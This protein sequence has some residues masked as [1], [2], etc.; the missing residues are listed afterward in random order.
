M[1]IVKPLRLKVQRTPTE[2]KIAPNLGVAKVLVDTGIFHLSGTYDYAVPIGLDTKAQPGTLVEVPF[3]S[4]VCSGYIVSRHSEATVTG[5][6]KFISKVLSPIPIFTQ[7]LHALLEDV[8]KLFAC[9]VWDLIRSAIPPRVAKVE[10]NFSGRKPPV[11]LEARESRSPR[12]VLKV[13]ST[14]LL[15]L[16]SQSM[17]QATNGSQVLVIVPDE[18]EVEFVR[19]RLTAAT[20]ALAPALYLTSKLEK[21]DRYRNFLETI[22]SSPT[23]IVG[24]R[25]AI[26]T[27]LRAG[28]RIIV[29]SDG[30]ES[31]YEKRAPGWNVRDVA[32][33]RA[34]ENEVV[35]ISSSPSLEVALASTEKEEV[36]V[37]L[38]TYYFEGSR[39]SDIAIVK[40]GL[41]KGNVL[42]VLPQPG[43]VN[44]FSCQKCRNL[45]VCECGGRLAVTSAKSPPSC[46]LCSRQYP[47]WV[48]TYCSSD[49]KR[50][51]GKGS[52]RFAEELTKSIPGYQ[53]LTS[54]GSSR[55][56][57][58]PES[59]KGPF[60]V[61]A[62]YGCEPI[63]DYQAL[64]LHS[65]E[66]LTNRTHL[67]ASEE[68]RA[69]IFDDISL[70]LP[71]G[72]IYLALT[73]EHPIARALKKDPKNAAYDLA[74]AEIAERQGANLPPVV[75]MACVIGTK[76]DISQLARSIDG[77]EIFSSSVVQTD[78]S[79]LDDAAKLVIRSRGVDQLVFAKFFE[80]LARY[81]S[82]K[83]LRPFNIRLQ[84]YSI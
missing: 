23:L 17:A 75:L 60:L 46:V 84:P 15:K 55:L 81:R 12:S 41:K 68:A 18:R 53:V 29:L 51:V 77:L 79:T 42:V 36:L 6:L 20:S 48:C 35:F 66:N 50:I 9:G 47:N 72:D 52:D 64:I 49:V 39:K 28:S 43:Y 45:A 7:D 16:V 26:F 62:T 25:S 2:N 30:D 4:K 70:V 11:D 22:F 56:D 67:R 14:D 83:G 57:V 38:K 58:L 24:T 13:S 80:D 61:I 33:I 74:H 69:R 32:L 31:M 37:P 5:K 54:K 19:N 10:N 82:L 73:P 44:T 71:G 78:K 34:K 65:L 27:P 40:E 59:S 21:S 76:A 63:G 8:A 1:A 3:G